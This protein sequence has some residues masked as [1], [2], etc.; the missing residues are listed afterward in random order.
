MENLFP[1]NLAHKFP[2][3]QYYRDS[4]TGPY[5]WVQYLLLGKRWKANPHYWKCSIISQCFSKFCTV[6]FIWGFIMVPTCVNSRPICKHF[7]Q[8][9]QRVVIFFNRN[10]VFWW[11]QPF[12]EAVILLCRLKMSDFC[13]GNVFGPFRK[14]DFLIIFRWSSGNWVLLCIVASQGLISRWVFPTRPKKQKRFFH[15]PDCLFPIFFGWATSSQRSVI[16]TSDLF[17][18]AKDFH[19][20]TTKKKTQLTSVTLCF[21]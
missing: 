8:Y 7:F 13:W 21:S 10:T 3:L 4:V 15:V 16:E 2:T 9:E 17:W 6:T 18:K 20:F 1:T 19:W 11:E 5:C 14:P 12:G